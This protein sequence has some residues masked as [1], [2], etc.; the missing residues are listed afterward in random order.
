MSNL[1]LRLWLNHQERIF[2]AKNFLAKYVALLPPA[3]YYKQNE[4]NR[5]ANVD[6]VECLSR[7]GGG[8]WICG[9]HA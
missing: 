3:A 8:E 4:C 7:G 9:T 6:H 5:S 1:I 2:L